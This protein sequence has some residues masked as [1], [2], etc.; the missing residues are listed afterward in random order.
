MM[1]MM[2]MMTV[3]KILT[4]AKLFIF[5]TWCTTTA[6]TITNGGANLI[7]WLISALE[8]LDIFPGL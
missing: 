4:I 1:M 8:L 5:E 2:M 6:A 3:E 7:K